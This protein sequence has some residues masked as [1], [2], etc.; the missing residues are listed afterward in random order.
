MPAPKNKPN[1]MSEPQGLVCVG[2][3]SDSYGVRGDIRLKTFTE[4]PAAL[5]KFKVFFL[6]TEL[7]PLNITFVKPIKSEFV[8]SVAGIETPEAAKALKGV[9][10]F[11][12]RDEL[13]P[14][15][16]PDE[17]YHADLV[18]LAVKTKSGDRLGQVSGLHDFGAGEI[19]EIIL[20]SPKK[21]VGKNLLVPFRGDVVGDINIEKGTMVIDPTGWLEEEN[22]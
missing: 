11:V 9:K 3:F 6:G 22:K 19:I 15:T 8:V 21:G 20:D 13:A 4:T 16:G 2:Q 10:V 17:Y 12:S 1:A 7:K 14:L 18:G 5:K